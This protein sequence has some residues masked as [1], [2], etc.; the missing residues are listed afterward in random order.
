MTQR[1]FRTRESV[2]WMV[3][4][5]PD[6]S[7]L[8]LLNRE[9]SFEKSDR[10]FGHDIIWRFA[11]QWSGS[12]FNPLIAFTARIQNFFQ[13]HLTVEGY[14]LINPKVGIWRSCGEMKAWK[15]A[16][17]FENSSSLGS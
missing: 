9:Q 13:E 12:F 15:N 5:G 2:K 3:L 1:F 11:G 14:P 8:P 6:S 16:H 7:S 17:H 10:R 4:R